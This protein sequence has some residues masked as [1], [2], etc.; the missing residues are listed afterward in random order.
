MERYVQL[1]LLSSLLFAAGNALLKRGVPSSFGSVPVRNL[2]RR[3]HTF[4]GALLRNP[5]WTTGFIIVFAAMALETQALGDGDV[6]VAAIVDLVPHPLE[7]GAEVRDAQ[8]ARAHADP[9]AS[10]AV[11]EGH[12]QNVNRVRHRR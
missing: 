6:D 9:A 12:S 7:G 8:G 11:V 5:S 10:G 1:T 2:L 4:I 3:P